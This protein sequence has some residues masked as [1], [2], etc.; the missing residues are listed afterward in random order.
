MD[1]INSK[2][3]KDIIKANINNENFSD[4]GNN[5]NLLSFGMDSITFIKIIIS[6]E[7]F[8]N[9]EIPDSKLIIS[10]MDTINKIYNVIKE[11]E[12]ITCYE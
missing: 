10:E 5:D 12:M 6:L 11:N 4:I 1:K 2:K 7:D 8:F 3:I 9:C